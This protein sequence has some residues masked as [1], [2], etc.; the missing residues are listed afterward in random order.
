MLVAELQELE[1]VKGL[2]T[3][4]QQFGVLTFGDGAHTVTFYS[5]DL[6]GN[7]EAAKSVSFKVD[8]SAP[9]VTYS[10]NAGVYTVDPTVTLADAPAGGKREPRRPG[11]EA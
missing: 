6:I 9:T 2:I 1:E 7:A 4:G 5:T 10:G 8:Q 11:D 3:R